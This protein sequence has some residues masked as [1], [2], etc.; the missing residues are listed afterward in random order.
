MFIA[1]RTQM[2]WDMCPLEETIEKI[3]QL[4]FSGVEICLENRHFTPQMAYISDITIKKTTE[5]IEETSLQ[6]VSVGCHSDFVHFDLIYEYIKSAIPK[7]RNFGAKIFILGAA[8]RHVIQRE[9]PGWDEETDMF[10]TRLRAL[11]DIAE[12][13]GVV[14]APEPEIH[15]ILRTSQELLDLMERIDSPALCVNFDIGHSFLT[16][17]D[18]IAMIHAFGD[19]IVHTHIEN[20]YRGW[21]NHQLPIP[22]NGDMDLHRYFQAL[23][24]ID[25][26]GNLALDLYN[27]S[28]EKIAAE[29]IDSLTDIITNISELK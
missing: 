27:H 29:C 8:E 4:G 18:P 5:Q 14:L 11:C 3:A 24:E 28:L 20:M 9:K 10:E 12:D 15:C 16:D 1:A 21:H 17:P 13:S 23:K 2:F 22:G 19:R 25:F 6:E 26:K 7:T